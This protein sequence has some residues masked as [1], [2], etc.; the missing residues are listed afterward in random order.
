[1][2]QTL[3]VF[4]KL[5]C[6]VQCTKKTRAGQKLLF[7]S[8]KTTLLQT[9]LDEAFSGKS[10]LVVTYRQTL[11]YNVASKLPGFVNYL[12]TD[13]DLSWQEK[14][15]RVIIQ[16]DS[17][18]RVCAHSGFLAAHFDLVVCDEMVSLL[19]HFASVTF[20]RAVF[21][22]GQFVAILQQASRVICMDALWGES[23]YRFLWEANIAQQLI[24]NLY[25]SMPRTF[26]VTHDIMSWQRQMQEDLPFSLR[27]KAAKAALAALALHRLLYKH[28]ID[29]VLIKMSRADNIKKYYAKK[30]YNQ[31]LAKRMC[32]RR[33]DGVGPRIWENLVSRMT[34]EL[35]KAN[36]KRM[37]TFQELLGCTAHDLVLQ[38]ESQFTDGMSFESY[39][40]WEVDHTKPI[41]SYDLTDIDQMMEAFHHTNLQPLWRGDN[42]RKGAKIIEMRTQ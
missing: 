26:T 22:A 2:H 21:T 33:H 25:K 4:T 20:D 13:E 7:V 3:Y 16:I 12:D 36:V 17:L 39:G 38:L 5:T 15:P 34:A 31:Q 24:I 8:G 27:S 28:A 14:Y 10:V 6:N 1:M 32:Q 40:E 37:N 41:A 30:H 9:L 29:V 18:R 11:A 23:C 35:S 42:R 19:D